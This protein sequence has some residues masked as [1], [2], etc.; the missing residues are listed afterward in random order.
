MKIQWNKV[1]WYSTLL[2]AILFIGLPFLWLWVGVRYGE[3]IGRLN[4][5]FA[6]E[7]KNYPVQSSNGEE[8]YGNP[9]EWQTDQDS[10]GGFSIAYPIDFSIDQ[11]YPATPS[12]DWRL[13]A[14]GTAGVKALAIT[15]P[16]AFEPQTNFVD[17]T[18]TV[19]RSANGAAVAGCLVPDPTAGEDVAT[20]T[21]AIN[22]IAFT[23]FHSNDA[24]AGNLYDTTSYRT[25]HGGQ[26]Y[27][28]E[29][30]VHSSQ[31]A[32]Y[33]ASYDLKPYNKAAV[34]GLFDRIVGTFKFL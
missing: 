25:V 19:G 29:Y 34:T 15:I 26:C 7:G 18:L 9:A 8:Y 32:N 33:P 1:T 16:S 24:G 31:V 22:G 13:G 2:A 28:L 5:L 6:L 17:A 4:T 23:V 10:A 11:N 30:T 14:N 21:M 12:T 20:S 3:F 27:A